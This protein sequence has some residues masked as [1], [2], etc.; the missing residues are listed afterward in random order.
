MRC[1]MRNPA[2]RDPFT[3]RDIVLSEQPTR[4]AIAAR[5]I[6]CDSNHATHAR[7]R[8]MTVICQET[9][10]AS[11]TAVKYARGTVGRVGAT[12]ESLRVGNRLR[13]L[14]A[15]IRDELGGVRG[16]QSTA[17]ERVGLKESLFTKI[18]NEEG[19][20]AQLATAMKVARKLGMDEAFFTRSDLG[21]R[22]SYRDWVGA[23]SVAVVVPPRAWDDFVR[24]GL[25]RQLN[26]TDEERAHLIRAAGRGEVQ[27]VE[28]Y[29]RGLNALRGEYPEDP[30]SRKKR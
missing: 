8:A 27:S 1:A 22:T 6:P 5:V 28:D 10:R 12:P 16:W 2:D 13:G 11:S 18:L 7:N 14:F 20:G 30:E 3:M 19:R 26:V 24:L 29:V 15:E 21:A 23:A 17:A 25:D 9:S 4:F